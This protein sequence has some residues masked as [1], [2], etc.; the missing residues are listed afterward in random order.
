MKKQK[1]PAREPVQLHIDPTP[2]E[3]TPEYTLE[4]IM[5]EF[6]GWTKREPE[7]AAAFPEPEPPKPEKPEETPTPET[8]E[9]PE[10]APQEAE[11]VRPAEPAPKEDKQPD[12]SAQTMRFAPVTAEPPK[13]EQPTIWTYKG[14]PAPEAPDVRT[15]LSKDELRERQRQKKLERQRQKQEKRRARRR[16][17]PER[18]FSSPEEAY[19]FYCKPDSLRLRLLLCCLLTLASAV[20]LVL[21]AGVFTAPTT[22][23]SLFSAL[24]L[25]FM[26]LQA[27]LCLDVLAEG[28]FAAIRLKFD[29][30]SML[31][32]VVLVCAADA[33]FALTG[34]RIPFCTVVSVE[35][36][37]GLW[38]RLLLKSAK[39]RTMKAVC[40]MPTPTGAVRKGSAWHG[41]DCIFRVPGDRAA[42]TAQ[43]EMP[44]A[45]KRCARICTPVAAL[46]TLALSALAALRS[47]HNF[48]WAWS[49]MLLAA[50]PSG[51]FLSFART[52]QR[53]STRLYR[54][55]AALSGWSGAR[56][57]SGECAVTITDQDLFPAGSVTL[58]GMK[59]YSDRSVSQIIGF[60][61][62]VVQTA[63]SGLV[64]LFDE[65]MHSQNGRHYR[66]DTFR[67]YEGG[68]LGA[69]IQGDVILMGSIGFMKLMKVRMPEGT[70][71]K[72]AVY[73]SVNG[74]L[75]AVFALNY[76]PAAGIRSGLNAAVHASGLLPLLATRDFM[77]TPQFLKLRYKIA[78]ERVEFPTVEERAQL[79]EPNAGLGGTQGALLARDS[80]EGFLAAVSGARA[81]RGAAIGSIA[82][83]VMGGAMGMLVLTF[84]TFLGAT[85]SASCWN[86]FLYTLLW[87]APGILI[88]SLS[89]RR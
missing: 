34:G 49:A 59:I 51:L 28:F 16:E 77:I 45:A 46:L 24:M 36:T 32:L 13:P 38:S 87:L 88:T 42:F 30:N 21:T 82:I 20:L 39:Y 18:T 23:L 66:V 70:R 33:V 57:L 53:Q 65:M 89:S 52:F 58:N 27:I 84:L 6:G 50:F 29:L 7:P 64:P 3:T 75:A 73:L 85:L 55:G 76:A 40:S 22:H 67:R 8:S 74:D 9:T 25:I 71:L 62:A 44:D 43:L 17:Q 26:I 37:V 47:E 10:A 2:A 1:L 15:R 48:L 60:A 11:A 83:A 69:E 79:S 78:S 35:L 4:D 14:E 63:G 5:N 86:L 68:G 56:V 80:F 41:T 81:M 72:Q 31:L 12:L 19:S 61:S 54:Y